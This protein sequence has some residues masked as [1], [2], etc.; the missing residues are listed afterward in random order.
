MFDISLTARRG[1]KKLIE[2]VFKQPR[3]RFGTRRKTGARPVNG[4]KG[5]CALRES[6]KDAVTTA[7]A[8]LL[9]PK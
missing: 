6:C 1:T 8:T 3:H 2:A 7:R 9:E 5:L 4:M